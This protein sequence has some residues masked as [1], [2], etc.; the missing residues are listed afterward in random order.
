MVVRK[1]LNFITLRLE[2]G[3]QRNHH[4]VNRNKEYQDGV[5]ELVNERRVLLLEDF[6][7]ASLLSR[8]GRGTCAQRSSN[9]FRGGDLS[10]C[11][12]FVR[13]QFLFLRDLRGLLLAT[14]A[15]A[16]RSAAFVK[17]ALLDDQGRRVKSQ[18]QNEVA[19]D[20]ARCKVRKC[21]NWHDFRDTCG[22]EGGEGGETGGERHSG[23][24]PKRHG[25]AEFVVSFQLRVGLHLV[26][27]IREHKHIV[28]PN[29][30]DHENCKHMEGLKIIHLEN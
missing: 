8:R 25:Q 11:G 30:K 21:R 24:P 7:H 14:T 19:H 10:S 23:R 17:V 1:P 26:P 27:G 29:P 28:G 18:H 6:L 20:H 5:S 9:I 15:A 16:A 4:H 12:E 22:H 3:G 2:L 13:G